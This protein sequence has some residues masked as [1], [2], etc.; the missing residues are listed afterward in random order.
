EIFLEA[1]LSSIDLSTHLVVL[2]SDHGNL[3]DLSTRRH[4][5]NPVPALFWGAG[6]KKASDGVR[7]ISDIAPAI[8]R[9]LDM[10]Y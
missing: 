6:A 1:V 3:E 2:T 5:Q 10:V 9:H 7:T 4:T 8:L